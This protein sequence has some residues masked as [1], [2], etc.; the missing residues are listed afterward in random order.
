ML[1]GANCGGCGYPG[2][3]GYADGVVNGGA[4]TS[5]CAAGGAEMAKN[6]AAVMGV[7]SEDVVPVRAF[8]KCKG[9]PDMSA[10]NAIYDG[11]KDCRSAAVLPGGTPNA[12]PF[13]CIG[14]GTCAKVCV[15][16]A[17]SIVN[18]LASVDPS[19]CIGCGTCVATCPKSILTLIPR[20]SDVQVACN[21]NWR[22]PEVKKVC[23]AGC[24][25]CGICAR[26][27]P[28]AAITVDGNLARVDASKCTNCGTCVTKCPTKSICRVLAV[29]E[30]IRKSA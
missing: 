7:E 23:K 10:R 1:P 13:G 9:S 16:G 25:G 22:G 19:R 20:S 11:I 3:D 15:F 21:S 6:I 28:A 24:I 5:L 18:G 8:L 27:C 29:S 4:K 30:E 26:A 12:C 17:M 2:C 14:L